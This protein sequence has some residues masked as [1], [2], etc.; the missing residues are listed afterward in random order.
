MDAGRVSYRVRPDG[1][2]ELETTELMR[3]YGALQPVAQS[4]AQPMAQVGTAAS[5]PVPDHLEPLLEELRLLRGEVR[6]LRQA[7]LLL[8]HKPAA[9]DSDAGVNR[10]SPEPVRNQSPPKTFADLLAGL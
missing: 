7:L 4:A 2:R 3:A 10:T 5:V 1:R 9:S 6:E 8:E